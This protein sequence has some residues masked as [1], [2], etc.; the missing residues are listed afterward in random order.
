VAEIITPVRHLLVGRLAVSKT[1]SVA[2]TF[3]DS[4]SAFI[5][6][7]SNGLA[8]DVTDHSKTLFFGPSSESGTAIA[9]LI[10]IDY[11]WSPG[12]WPTLPNCG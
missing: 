12:S 3:W 6:E 7:G 2:W 9:R 4:N 5:G 1:F 11:Q 8:C 10:V